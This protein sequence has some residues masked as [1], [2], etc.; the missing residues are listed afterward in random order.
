LQDRR[1]VGVALIV[2]A[3]LEIPWPVRGPA[4]TEQLLH[5]RAEAQLGVGEVREVRKAELERTV[6]AKPDELGQLFAE[7]GPSIRGEAH[8]LVFALVDLE[9]EVRGEPGVEQ[10]QRV[11]VLDAAE[12]AELG[13]LAVPQRRRGRLADPIDG[14]DRGPR[15]GADEERARRVGAVMLGGRDPVARDAELFC[16]SIDHPDLAAELRAHRAGELPQRARKRAQGRDK[17]PFELLDRMFVEHDAIE[18]ARGEP[19]VRKARARGVDRQPCIVLD[20]RQPLLLHRRDD[21]TVD[22][23]RRGG[24]VVLAGDAE[25]GRHQRPASRAGFE[26]STATRDSEADPSAV[27]LPGCSRQRAGRF[28]APRPTAA[29]GPATR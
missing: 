18:V 29:T 22:D 10:A 6:V 7:A 8:H 9:A 4:W 5:G 19:G 24:V 12:L 21:G 25:H 16:H 14:E 17:H 13:A 20:P 28:T 27:D 15:V 1:D 11:R 23:E 26:S 2:G 3:V